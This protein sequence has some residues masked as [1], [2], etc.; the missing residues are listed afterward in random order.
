MTSKD[1]TF[2]LLFKDSNKEDYETLCNVDEDSFVVNRFG[3]T[4]I[5]INCELSVG[6]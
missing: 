1:Y 2:L 6:K 4:Y 3:G 5:F